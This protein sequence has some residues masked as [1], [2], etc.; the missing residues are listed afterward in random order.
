MKSK[1]MFLWI[2]V[3]AT[4]LFSCNQQKNQKESKGDKPNILLIVADDL[5]FSDIASF[6]GNIKTPVYRAICKRRTVIFK[7]PCTAY[8]FT[9]PFFTA[10]RK[11]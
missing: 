7:F 4:T 10:D 2:F 5:G 1:K 8:L 3:V 9:N 6:G 11:R